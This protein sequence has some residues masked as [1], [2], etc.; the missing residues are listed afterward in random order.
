M[1]LFRVLFF[2]IT[3]CLHGFSQASAEPL[4]LQKGDTFVRHSMLQSMD[5]LIDPTRQLQAGTILQPE[6]RARFGPIEGQGVY[7]REKGT[8][9]LFFQ[10][11]NRSEETVSLHLVHSATYTDAIDLYEA[12]GQALKWK[13]ARGD[14][15]S[16]DLENN[17]RLPLFSLVVTPGLH[18]YVLR[19]R[20]DGPVSVKF[21]LWSPDHFTARI[22]NLENTF[23]GLLFGFLI[24]M[25]GYNS[26]IAIRL[27]VRYYFLYV[28]YIICFSGVQLLFSGVARQFLP[29]HPVTTILLNQGVIIG[30]ELTAIFACSFAIRFLDL[31]QVPWLMRAMTF[32]YLC[33]AINI[34]ICLIDFHLSYTTLLITN[35][36]VSCLLFY[37]GVHRSIQKYRPAYFYTAAWVFLLLGSLISMTYI[38]GFVPENGFVI[39]SQFAGAAVEG[40]LLSLALSD[41]ISLEREQS[42]A[43]ISKLNQQL[44][45]HVEEVES[46]VE[47]KTRDIRSIMEHIPLGIFMIEDDRQIHKDYSRELIDIFRTQDIEDH[48]ATALLFAGSLLDPDEKSQAI[49]CL[50]AALGEDTL[51]FEMNAHALPLHLSRLDPKGR[52]EFFDLTWNA[53][54]RHPARVDKILV[55]IRD[56]TEIRSLQ[57]QSHEQ[58][59][60]LELIGEILKVPD[61]QF[62][63]FIQTAHQLIDDT[64][65]LIHSQAMEGRNPEVLKIVFINM[66]T[67]KGSARSLYLRKLTRTIHDIEQDLAHLQ[68]VPSANWDIPRMKQQMRDARTDVALYEQIARNKLG[69]RLEQ[70]RS[71]DFRLDQIQGSYIR[72][73]GVLQD[74]ELPI[75]IS[76]VICDVTRLFHAQIF[77]DATV[78]FQEILACLPQL[79]KDLY[80][81]IPH[82]QMETQ[83]ILLSDKAEELVRNTCVH[84]LRNSM[85]HGIE[86]A[87]ERR[88][89]GKD[90]KGTIVIDMK[91][92]NEHVELIL[93]DDG[94]GLPIRKII[95]I[96]LARDL[97]KPEHQNDRERVAQL[98]FDSGLSTANRITDISGRGIG[99]NA[100]KRFI[101]QAGGTVRIVWRDDPF[102]P[103]AFCPFELIISLPFEGL[104]ETQDVTTHEAA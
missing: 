33:S 80:K 71:V 73:K 20:T 50:H 61:L 37:A 32:F 5:L 46:I 22:L 90:P 39:W 14:H 102:K 87:A 66:H 54:E 96:G 62:S 24:V 100:V 43:Q 52:L 99:M 85:D 49:S 104:F 98:P 65:A 17:Y 35:T 1:P 56:V 84:L 86:S 94:R 45:M 79:A 48:E 42:H 36:Y 11:D 23:I 75:R 7:L 70:T 57:K 8:F 93:S 103:Q 26:F 76:T 19:I 83:G 78:V 59:E 47:V 72:L 13:A 51:N 31:S 81:D 69:R 77:K 15:V 40:V 6:V 10:I 9:W 34:V 64:E 44:Q 30:G 92:R 16:Q 29:N 88:R 41:R 101:E 55:T 18:T 67:I 12:Q 58:Q 21:N 91:R 97:L 60:E 53:I 95:E 63:R 28:G 25:I 27:R 4:I 89:A 74:P 82:V 3:Y 38:Y 68:K 2:M